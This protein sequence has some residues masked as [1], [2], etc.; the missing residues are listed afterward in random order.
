MAMSQGYGVSARAGGG[1]P[2]T[3]AF[4]S[5]LRVLILL[6]LAGLVIG[7]AL[8][9]FGDGAILALG[10]TATGF[11]FSHQDLIWF[12]LCLAIAVYVGRAMTQPLPTG[13]ASWV[14][15]NIPDTVQPTRH[16]LAIAVSVL[17]LCIAGAILLYQAAEPFPGERAVAFQAGVFGEGVLAAP[18]AGEWEDYADALAPSIAVHDPDSGVWS[19]IHAPLLGAV[20]AALD[21]VGLARVTNAVFAVLSVLLMAGIARRLWP[22][23]AEVPIL[24]AALLATSPQFLMDGMSGSAWGALLCLNLAWLWLFLR[25]DRPG[26]LCAAVI[27]VI[28]AGLQHLYMHA[29]FV[30]PFLLLVLRERRWLLAGFYVIAYVTGHLIWLN[31]QDLALAAMLGS[32]IDPVV[33]AL[34]TGDGPAPVLTWPDGANGAL[35][36]LNL[37]RLL[38]WMNLIVIPLAIVALRPWSGLP[39]IFRPLALGILLALLCGVF[40]MPG[41]QDGWGYGLLH[42]HLGSFVLLATL[43]WMR[44]AAAKPHLRSDLNR[45][46]GLCCV[47]MVMIAIPL[48]TVQVERAASAISASHG[49][50]QEIDAD[51]VLV[52]MP[53]IWFGPD[54]VRNDPFLRNRPKV[55]GL[56]LLTADQIRALCDRYTVAV[57]DHHDL[58]P[59]GVDPMASAPGARYPVAA[60]DRAL[61]AIATGPRC[62]GG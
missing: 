22:D 13:L 6:C 33:A 60:P 5:G 52:D 42:G 44:L 29:V 55:M 58:A 31:W 27:G 11:L 39:A 40:L 53:G 32:G 17:V 23:Q 9:R 15:R 45:A 16:L 25:D 50:I 2:A 48:R 8:R 54:L 14:D 7:F 43:G 62:N 34:G 56:Q 57:I 20:R 26:H 61:R 12:G 38:G 28:A 35:V 37:L 59:Y 3:G 18:V 46:V 21:V 1:R 51:V 19:P 4:R 47:A 30:L 36:G 49:H 10:E 41:R 24:A